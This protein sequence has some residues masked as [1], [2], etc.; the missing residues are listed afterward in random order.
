MHIDHIDA[1]SDTDDQKPAA[2]WKD[3]LR[4]YHEL[5]D[6]YFQLAK[7]LPIAV[8]ELVMQPV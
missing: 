7:T 3:R 1:D 5:V 8:R 2:V 4:E 6:E